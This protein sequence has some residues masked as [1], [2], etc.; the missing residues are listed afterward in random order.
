MST[1]CTDTRL[2]TKKWKKQKK[3]KHTSKCKKDMKKYYNKI[4]FCL[5]INKNMY[6]AP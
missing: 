2:S 4:L 6:N 5:K 1:L 3:E